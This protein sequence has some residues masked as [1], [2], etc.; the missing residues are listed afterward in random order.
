MHGIRSL[1]LPTKSG[2]VYTTGYYVCLSLQ[3]LRLY[4]Q[5]DAKFAFALRRQ[6]PQFADSV[7]LYIG[8]YRSLVRIIA[9]E[10]IRSVEIAK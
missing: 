6:F 4:A 8:N 2:V 7:T 3:N 9:G 5:W 10:Q 1:S